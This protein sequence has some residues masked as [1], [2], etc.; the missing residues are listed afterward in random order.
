MTFEQ[1][2]RYA[3]KHSGLS[4]RGLALK[5][6]LSAG[7]FPSLFRA[8][9]KDPQASV[10]TATVRAIAHAAGVSAAWLLTGK[11]SPDDHDET[12]T[13][14]P[15]TAHDYVMRPQFQN[16]P[17][18]PELLARAKEIDPGLPGWVWEML[19]RT[20]PILSA[21]PTPAMVAELGRWMLRHESLMRPPAP[22]KETGPQEVPKKR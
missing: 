10:E 7:Y 11:G 9:A 15:S 18:W 2:I 13:V 3:I 4:P 1:R 6:G 20:S 16:L 17:E 5:A 8:L 14:A 21:P 19:A 12:E 22:R